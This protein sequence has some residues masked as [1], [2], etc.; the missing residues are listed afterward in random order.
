[1]RITDLVERYIDAIL[2]RNDESLYEQA[3]PEL[4]EHYHTFWSTKRPYRRDL[5]A[6]VL[7]GQR[8]LVRSR[9]NHVSA[10]FAAHHWDLAELEFVL[11]VGHGTTNG[12]AFRESGG[13]VVW[14]PVE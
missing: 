11:F 12:H 5:E 6:T 14:V 9:L 4:F 2:V 10:C 8:Q 13:F 3:L 7:R 1:M